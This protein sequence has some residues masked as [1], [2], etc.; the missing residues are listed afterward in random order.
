MLAFQA[1][2][3]K[4]NNAL[5]YGT[6]CFAF[7][8]SLIDCV[9]QNL[10]FLYSSTAYRN[11]FFVHMSVSI[12]FCTNIPFKQSLSNYFETKDF[13][14]LYIFLRPFYSE[15]C[16]ISIIM[17]FLSNFMFALFCLYHNF[18]YNHSATWMFIFISFTVN[19]LIMALVLMWG[20]WSISSCIE[21]VPV[22]ICCYIVS[23]SL[24]LCY[25]L[26]QL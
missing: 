5:F 25:P 8:S 7:D 18:C 19:C 20:L 13:K 26:L 17:S 2:C 16:L 11:M 4:L 24:V 10:M 12:C 6:W 3:D 22:F 14:L 9:L 1:R 21:S 15:K 23:Y